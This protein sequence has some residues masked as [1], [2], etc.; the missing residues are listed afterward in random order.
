[1][2]SFGSFLA[3]CALWGGC[4]SPHEAPSHDAGVSDAPVDVSPDADVTGPAVTVTLPA[5]NDAE[6]V[7]NTTVKVTFDEPITQSSLTADSF[8]LREQETGAS[9]PGTVVASTSGGT[10]TPSMPLRIDRT[11]VAT[12]T[13]AVTDLHGNAVASDT[14]WM[15]ATHRRQ[16]GVATPVETTTDAAQ[17]PQVVVDGNGNAIAV[18]RQD[19][20]TISNLWTNRYVPATGWGTP[21]LLETMDDGD[22]LNPRLAINRAGTAVVVWEQDDGTTHTDLYVRRYVVGTGWDTA[23]KIGNPNGASAYGADIAIDRDGRI[24]VVWDQ[25]PVAPPTTTRQ[26]VYAQ[27]YV[28]GSGWDTA[29]LIETDET[30]HTGTVRVTIDDAGVA[31]AVWTI[32]NAG[33]SAFY[34]WSNRFV[35]GQGWG[36]AERVDTSNSTYSRNPEIAADPAGN[37][38]VV[39]AELQGAYNNIRSNRYVAGTGWSANPVTL[40]TENLGHAV[41]VK[42]AVSKSGVAVAVWQQ[43]DGAVNS[44]VAN[45]FD[46]TAWGTFTRIET[47]NNASFYPEVDIDDAGDALVVWSAQDGLEQNLYTNHNRGGVWGSATLLETEAGAG[48]SAGVAVGGGIGLA[49]WTQENGA[50]KNIVSRVFK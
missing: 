38:T 14:S 9:V 43:H 26:S 25:F 50:E 27:R 36:T 24:V 35:P 39:W 2:R 10:F 1:M 13:T 3:V 28:P 12:I 41:L 16:F 31:T 49:I 47:S 4:S 19:V 5:N 20:G 21:A 46:G 23:T 17:L 48:Y 8:K 30:G 40:E 33:A 11:Y 29:T 45:R 34:L 37:V 18:W 22:A 7:N 44:V 42:V 15:F 6:V 32:G